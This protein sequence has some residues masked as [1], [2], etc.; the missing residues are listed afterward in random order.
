MPVSETLS[1]EALGDIRRE[2]KRSRDHFGAAPARHLG[3]RLA[4]R[5]RQISAGTALGHR[6][7]MLEDAPSIF[8]CITLVPLLIIYNAETRVVL[9]V[10]DGRRD[11]AAAL[12][13]RLAGR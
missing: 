7:Q 8:L 10:V 5:L 9:M 4:D 13:R 6:H 2:L 12:A 3:R 11:V 1:V